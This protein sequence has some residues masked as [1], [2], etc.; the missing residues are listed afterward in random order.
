MAKD[1]T[2]TTQLAIRLPPELIERLDAH[3]ERMNR[4]HPGLGATRTDAVRTLLT[5]ALDRVE[6]AEPRKGKRG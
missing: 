3:A 2:P 5:A 6:A 1:K 4:E